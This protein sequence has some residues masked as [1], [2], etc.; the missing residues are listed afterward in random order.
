MAQ[1]EVKLLSIMYY[2][3]QGDHASPFKPG[4]VLLQGQKGDVVD[5]HADD[6]ERF[7]RINDQYDGAIVPPDHAAA[8]ASVIEDD[9]TGG[10]TPTQS[11]R[12]GEPGSPEAAADDD[13]PQ[14][15]RNRAPLAEWQAYAEDVGVDLTDDEG[16]D[17]TKAQLIQETDELDSDEEGEEEA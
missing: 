2:D 1:R 16:D 11:T 4:A 5:V 7:D 15:P 6:L 10:P 14:R 3:A 8:F 13:E 9:N 17:K 12:P